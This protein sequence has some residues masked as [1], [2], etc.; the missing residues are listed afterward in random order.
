M[1]SED[2]SKLKSTP[3]SIFFQLGSVEALMCLDNQQNPPLTHISHRNL[4]AS[5]LTQETH[6]AFCFRIVTVIQSVNEFFQSNTSGLEGFCQEALPC[7]C[8][9]RSSFHSF[10]CRTG[11]CIITYLIV[12]CGCWCHHPTYARLYTA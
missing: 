9:Q 3:S 7:R 6:Q 8:W 2:Q 5:N 4:P 11:T 12:C 10:H 1:G